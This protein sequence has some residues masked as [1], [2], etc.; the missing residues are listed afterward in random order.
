[1]CVANMVYLDYGQHFQITPYQY[2]PNINNRNTVTYALRDNKC[3]QQLHAIA[4][5]STDDVAR[6]SSSSKT[7]LLH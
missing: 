4:K 3:S 5:P 2:F 6:P 1:M 7:K